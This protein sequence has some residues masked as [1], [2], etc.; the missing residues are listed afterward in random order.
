[1]KAEL[2]DALAREGL[3][4]LALETASAGVTAASEALEVRRVRER[5][6]LESGLDVLEAERDLARARFAEA[7]TLV[8]LALSGYRVSL[9]VGEKL[10]GAKDH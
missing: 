6:G 7:D 2:L 9:A 1:M 8:D 10:S 3:I 4:P 5:A